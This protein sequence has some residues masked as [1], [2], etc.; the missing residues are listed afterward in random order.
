MTLKP[1]PRISTRG[2]YNLHTGK[3]IKHRKPYFLYPKKFFDFDS[4]LPR[5]PKE[6]T[7]MMHGL[8][9]DNPSAIKKFKIAQKRLRQLGYPHPVVGFSYDSNTHG[10]HLKKSALH[11]LRIGQK[12]AKKNG[13]NLG[14]FI[15]DF[16]KWYPRTK[17]RLMGHSLGTQVILY[18]ITYLY[19]THFTNTQNIVESAHLFGSSIPTAHLLSKI[20]RAA[21]KKIVAKKVVNYYSPADDVLRHAHIQ[22]HI[23]DPIGYTGYG[24]NHTRNNKRAFRLDLLPFDYTQ[25]KVW[26]KNH[27][28]ASYARTITQFP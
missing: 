1:F 27:R 7:I 22:K 14:C 4:R 19:T 8:Q 20:N 13:K 6:I 15:L 17:I 28:F 12:I 18:T 23:V 21:F 11:A 26:P 25:K 16:K 10:A 3:T 2:H 24:P 9:N 5:T